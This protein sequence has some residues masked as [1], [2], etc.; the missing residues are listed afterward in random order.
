MN[1]SFITNRFL[2]KIKLHVVQYVKVAIRYKL[3][4]RLKTS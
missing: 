4:N 1:R 3:N 2:K